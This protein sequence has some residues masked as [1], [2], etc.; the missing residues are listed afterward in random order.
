[1]AESMKIEDYKIQGVGKTS[2]E[3]ENDA[4]EKM[5][6]ANAKINNYFTK[7]VQDA[8]DRLDSNTQNGVAS[9]G[10]PKGMSPVR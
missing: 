1:V 9:S 10:F 7:D 4:K 2:E 6:K 8:N 3:A 5:D